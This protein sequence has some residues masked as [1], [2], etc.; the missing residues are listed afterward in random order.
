M[1][2]RQLT[3]GHSPDPDD[4]FMFYALARDRLDTR[5]WTF[6]HVLQDIQTLNERAL[7]GELDITAISIHAYPYVADKYALTNCGSSMGD[8]YGPMVVARDPMTVDDL[9]GRRIA[10]PG[11]MTTAFL[12]LS[13]LLGKGAFEHTVVM[14]D[15]ILDH[16]A[17]GGAD[18]GL[19][20]HE[21][22]LT[23]QQH[24][25]HQ[26]L[27]LGEWWKRTTGLPLPLGGNCIRR[28]LGVEAM[29]EVTGILKRSIQYSLAHRAEAVEYA[30]QFA[31]NMGTELADRFVGMY[32][33]EW[34]IDYGE[35]GRRAV[36]ELLQR[37]HDAGLVPAVWEIDFVG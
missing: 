12:A 8:G 32:V 25:L 31:R 17:D 28:D 27:D 22:Q 35:T 19:V 16:V 26:V 18:A 2:K 11:E 9:R 20:I 30:V 29:T 4:A 23:F 24:E 10:I 1:V 33:N 13:L 21:G 36:R 6:E 15:Q 7:R 34:T 5:G 3:L 14:F 37:G